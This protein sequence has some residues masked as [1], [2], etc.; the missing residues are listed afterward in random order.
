M[1]MQTHMK[2]VVLTILSALMI[3]GVS[4]LLWDI[5][6]TISTEAGRVEFQNTIMDMGPMGCL[7]LIGLN[8]AQIFL[9]FFPGEPIE[10]LAG[11]CYGTLGGL[12]VIYVGVFI[13]SSIIFLLIRKV[14]KASVYDLIGKNKLERIEKSRI[15][16]SNN[17][18]KLLLLLFVMPGTPKDLLVY[19]GAL[20][21]VKASRFILL[22][23]IFRFPGII[24]STI[25]GESLTEGDSRFAL[26]VYAVTIAI[27]LIVL[28]FLRKKDD[29]REI[30]DI[31]RE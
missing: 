17:A 16:N 5:F 23:T 20:L 1:E 19:I 10:L 14:G 12:I 13:S 21:P 31:N 18:E 26:F 27:S 8:V 6:Q 9:F 25:V 30:I 7:M 22:S 3:I 4:A 24:T 29:I 15:F 2:K 11:M 28:F